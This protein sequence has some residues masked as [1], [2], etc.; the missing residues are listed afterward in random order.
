MVSLDIVAGTRSF[1]D[2]LNHGLPHKCAYDHD[3]RRRTPNHNIWNTLSR[4]P[5]A[6]ILQNL[7]QFNMTTVIPPPQLGLV[8]WALRP[9]C[10]IICWP[11]I[12]M[13]IVNGQWRII[14]CHHLPAYGFHWVS[15]Y[16]DVIMSAMASQITGVS[17]F[18]KPFVKVQIKEN[19][20]DPRQWLL[21]G[22]CDRW[23]P[24]TKNQ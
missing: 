17:I 20:K 11:V 2:T 12:N 18:T 23:I 9:I 3:W 19:I 1:F 15:H 14:F 16:I 6:Y 4:E 22:E 10:P 13:I 7:N 5:C 21:W 24:C 8:T